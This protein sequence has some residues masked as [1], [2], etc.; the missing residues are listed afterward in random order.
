MQ[1]VRAVFCIRRELELVALLKFT[2]FKFSMGIISLANMSH[3]VLL[4][5]ILIFFMIYDDIERYL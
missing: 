2:G 3:Y 4:Y 1:C 5:R